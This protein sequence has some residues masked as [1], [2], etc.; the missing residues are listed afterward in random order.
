[1]PII[2]PQNVSRDYDISSSSNSLNQLIQA[3]NAATQRAA[4]TAKQTADDINQ[5]NKMNSALIQ[6]E[7]KDNAEKISKD[8]LE[9]TKEETKLWENAATAFT[10]TISSGLGKLADEFEKKLKTYVDTY[11]KLS[12]NLIG[13]GVDYNAIQ[14]ALSVLGTNAFVKQTEVYNNLLRLVESGITLNAAQ[15]AY[16][17]TAGDQV[18][19]AFDMTST[20]LNNLVQIYHTDIAEAR[21]GQMAG[22]KIFLEQNYKNSQYIKEGFTQVSNA[23]FQMQSIMSVSAAMSTEKAIQTYLGSFAAAGGS[24]GQN[25]ATALGQLGSG[26][27]NL[28]G[29][30]NLMVMAAAQSGLSYADLLT[31]GLNSADT[32]RLMQGLFSYMANMSNI[33]GGSNV[34]MNAIAKIFGVSVSDIMAARNMNLGNINTGWNSSIGNFFG[35]FA[36]STSFS[37]KLSTWWDNAISAQ[38]FS[39]GLGGL[40]G[41]NSL[42]TVGWDL[43]KGITSLGGSA[44]QG[45]AGA[46]PWGLGVPISL[47]G[48]AISNLP[49]LTVLGGIL[50]NSLSGAFSSVDGLKSLFT[51]PTGFVQGLLSGLGFGSGAA[52]GDYLALGGLD[53]STQLSS[54]GSFSGGGASR[55]GKI[56]SRSG[57]E[58]NQVTITEGEAPENKTLD[59]LY[60]LLADDFPITTFLTTSSLNKEY[61]GNEVLIGNAE[62]T[63]HIT[64]M[65]TLT[66]VST[67]NILELLQE[68][69]SNGGLMALNNSANTN[70]YGDMFGSATR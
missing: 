50:N 22:L 61:G 46:T 55:S 2:N 36:N 45:A 12:F 26:D 60:S 48:S 54:S 37:S 25:I 35:N 65:I 27:F 68:A 64:D 32:E 47:L 4:D 21:A 59:D 44:L 24:A 29:M 5:S 3:I 41:P 33:A 66:A 69:F 11:Q 70:T 31:G 52:Y 10:A 51:D 15:R 23:L 13:S 38:A 49:G 28:G 34:A 43:F 53:G 17:K 8:K 1:M 16:L 42:G 6:R 67:Q 30:Q 7:E 40:F 63:E 20:T 62:I 58:T 9:K 19:L 14:G 39:G 56:T 57:P 18:G